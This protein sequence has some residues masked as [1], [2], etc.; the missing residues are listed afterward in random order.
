MTKYRIL[1]IPTATTIIV[2]TKYTKFPNILDIACSRTNCINGV[3]DCDT[4][5]WGYDEQYPAIR[6]AYVI[7]RL[8][9][10]S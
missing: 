2:D 10:E 8:K 3:M 1:H 9:N 7:G 5:P 4:C 6:A